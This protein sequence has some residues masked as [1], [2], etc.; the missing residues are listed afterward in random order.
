MEMGFG[1]ALGV[2]IG[3]GEAP[4]SFESIS[5]QAA[6]IFEALVLARSR[7]GILIM[8]TQLIFLGLC[9]LAA[10]GPA[11]SRN[12]R[13]DWHGFRRLASRLPV[14]WRW[15]DP[16]SG[17]DRRRVMDRRRSTRT[18]EFEGLQTE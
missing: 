9:M 1:L 15:D 5:Q 17:A 4:R 14:P 11:D 16:A 10:T 12:H 6:P 13:G 18:V 8:I 7:G 3:R 2:T